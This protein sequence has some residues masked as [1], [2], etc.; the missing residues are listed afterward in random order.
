[1]D[2]RTRRY[3]H[4]HARSRRNLEG[5]ATALG[6]SRNT[7]IER[8]RRLKAMP[9]IQPVAPPPSPARVNGPHE[10]LPAGHPS[11]WSLISD[12]EFPRY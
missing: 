6:I 2:P 5:N 4:N 8:G 12:Q 10:P 9:D 3:D 11:T 1:M 7:T